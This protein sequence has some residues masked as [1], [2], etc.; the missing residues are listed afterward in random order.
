M[1]KQ[2]DLY[3]DTGWQYINHKWVRKWEADYV[4][5]AEV[6]RS[7]GMWHLYFE[8]IQG[9]TQLYFG[10]HHLNNS[11]SLWALQR[12]AFAYFKKIADIKE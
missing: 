2:S 10:L 5:T 9:L 12:E 4:Y 11:M 7:G 1:V 8:P 6:S 3:T